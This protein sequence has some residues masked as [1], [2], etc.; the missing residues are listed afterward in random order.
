M[1]PLTVT[2]RPDGAARTLLVAGEVDLSGHDRLLHT[3]LQEV[4]TPGVTRVT[5]DLAGVTFL[6]STGIGVLIAGRNAAREAGVGYQVT[7]ATGI[8]REVL[9]VTGVDGALLGPDS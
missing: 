8:V 5:V 2:S 4:R 3:V 7:G 1:T 9:T 6:D